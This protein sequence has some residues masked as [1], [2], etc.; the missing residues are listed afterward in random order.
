[1]RARVARV[2][3]WVIVAGLLSSTAE[4]APARSGAQLEGSVGAS[5][6][7]P[8]RAD[9]TRSAL[10]VTGRMQPSFGGGVAVGARPRP[11]I[12]FMAMY[13]A[14]MFDPD[15]V[16]IDGDVLE[17]VLQHTAGVG[18]RPILPIWRFDLGLQ[19]GAAYSRQTAGY[20]EPGR[21]D[22]TQGFS[23]VTGVTVDLFVTDHVFVG[24]GADMIFDIHGVSCRRTSSTTTCGRASELS[25]FTPNHQLL[26]GLRVGT[27]FG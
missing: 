19:L 27:T 18:V 16:D 20:R 26:F 1:M 25:S 22:Y 15:Y 8:G 3:G 10:P 12:A 14:G 17:Y 21:R 24:A 9:C 13:R 5:V 2:G 11:W 7:I 4:A 6:C 23:I